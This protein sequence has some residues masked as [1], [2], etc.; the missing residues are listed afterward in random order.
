MS[1]SRPLQDAEAP[2]ELTLGS[3]LYGD[4]NNVRVSEG[5][6]VA[7]VAA[8]A[9][10]D[11]RALQTL[12]GYLHGYVFTIALRITTRR[13][14]A[15]EVAMDVFHD[16]WKRASRYS[17]ADGTVVGWV[18]NLAR[19]R[20]IDRLRYEKRKKRVASTQAFHDVPEV[21]PDLVE[22]RQQMA[23]VRG[24][25]ADLGQEERT[26]IELAYFS[27]ATYAEVAHHLG[28]PLGT[29]KSRIRSGLTK[30]RFTLEREAT[31]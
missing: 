20:A 9:A 7:L 2:S 11:V 18:M 17:P 27:D 12:Y 1:A 10:R 13:S 30:L 4:G 5:A 19:S 25:L 29:I 16:L 15:E 6:W 14:S 28:V 31:P 23:L 24:A 21:E 3:L 26:A 22:Q 8:V